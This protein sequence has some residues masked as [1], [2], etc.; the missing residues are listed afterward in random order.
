MTGLPGNISDAGSV[1]GQT[2]KRKEQIGQTIEIGN[3]QGWNLALLTQQNDTPFGPAA[4]GT[5]EVKPRTFWGPCRE[6][7]CP[8]LRQLG[9]GFID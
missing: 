9:V 1:V 2:G 8:K 7:K 4:D 6:N 5:S 3:K